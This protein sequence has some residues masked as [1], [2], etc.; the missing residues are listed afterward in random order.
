MPAES[1]ARP[2]YLPFLLW[3]RSHAGLSRESQGP[4]PSERNLSQAHSGCSWRIV[5]FTDQQRQVVSPV[6]VLCPYFYILK[7][8]C[9]HHATFGKHGKNGKAKHQPPAIPLTGRSWPP[10]CCSL[11]SLPEFSPDTTK[12]VL[13]AMI[14][15]LLTP[16]N[17]RICHVQGLAK[18]LSVWSSDS[19]HMWCLK[20]P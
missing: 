10:A 16:L 14:C 4:K 17:I 2:L 19:V 11:F 9:F 20:K 1:G 7:A 8:V 13:E 15:S 3:E 6:Q 5:E 18:P 12:I